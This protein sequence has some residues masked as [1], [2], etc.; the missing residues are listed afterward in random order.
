[1]IPSAVSVAETNRVPG[2][3]ENYTARKKVMA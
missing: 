1:M 2:D 3:D